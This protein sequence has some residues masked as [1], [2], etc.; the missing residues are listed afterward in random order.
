MKILSNTQERT[1][2]VENRIKRE[3]E[4]LDPGYKM[5]TPTFPNGMF[6]NWPKNIPLPTIEEYQAAE[7]R[8]QETVKENDFSDYR[9]GLAFVIATYIPSVWLPFFFPHESCKCQMQL[10]SESP[11]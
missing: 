11:I 3:Y 1:Q 7:V 10:S 4:I 5:K 9:C 6:L 2:R 8:Y